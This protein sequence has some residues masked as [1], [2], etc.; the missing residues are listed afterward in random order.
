[1]KKLLAS[2]IVLAVA[3]LSSTA[4][5][6]TTAST[7]AKPAAKATTAPVS[8]EDSGSIAVLKG[9]SLKLSDGKVFVLPASLKAPALKIGEKVALT[10]THSGKTRTITEVKVVN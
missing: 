4:F 10:Y 6:A 9:H 7:A 5:A 2:T 3:G 1:M 8:A